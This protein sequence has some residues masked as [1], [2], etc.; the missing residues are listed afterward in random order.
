MSIILL[1]LKLAIS[2]FRMCGKNAFTISDYFSNRMWQIYIFCLNMTLLFKSFFT[3]TDHL[4][5]K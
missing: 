4:L 5:Q 2:F 1:I 3:F